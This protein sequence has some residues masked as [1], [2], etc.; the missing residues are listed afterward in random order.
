LEA[1]R[2]AML[3]GICAKLMAK[4]GRR[5]DVRRSRG[6]W[7]F[8]K[9]WGSEPWKIMGKSWKKPWEN[10]DKTSDMSDMM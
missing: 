4:Q 5:R 8:G 9:R 3:L 10:H 2:R 1:A 6:L 7:C